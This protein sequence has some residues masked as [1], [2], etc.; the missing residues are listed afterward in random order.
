MRFLL[1]I[2][3]GLLILGC[4]LSHPA[5]AYLGGFEDQDG[6]NN[7]YNG[8]GPFGSGASNYNAFY[9]NAGDYGTNAGGPGGGPVDI[10][11]NTGSWRQLDAIAATGNR[12]TIAHAQ[13]G[14]EHSFE[15]DAM[16]GM[17]NDTSGAADLIARYFIDSRDFG[18]V[19]PGSSFASIVA[20][21]L[22]VCPDIATTGGTLAAPAFNWTFRD[23]SLNT[24]LM[25]G[26]NNNNT[27]IYKSASDSAWTVS[28]FTLDHLNYDRLDFYIDTL[29]S[30]WYLN[31]F[32]V[33]ANKTVSVVSSATIAPT[34]G[35]ITTID[36]DLTPNQSKNY[37]DNSS[38]SAV[39]EPSSTL[40]VALAALAWSTK[41]SRPQ[42][43]LSA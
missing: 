43:A 6:Y 18:G 35:A 17:R 19:T 42:H 16:L 28:S 20:W 36:W 40:L 33:S 12:Y 14:V 7:D 1:S 11:N 32:D 8:G 3:T 2:R 31:A 39:P 38:F 15:G 4:T 13:V 29:S 9:Y 41:R 23:A 26:W 10:P 34:M 37:F 25:V 27:L 21:S 30:T 22:R 24:G 5:L